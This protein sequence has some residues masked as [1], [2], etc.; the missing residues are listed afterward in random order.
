M[1]KLNSN[2]YEIDEINNFRE[3][4]DG[5]VRKYPN[6]IAYKFKKDLGKP[7]Q[8]IVEK[9]YKQIKEEIEALST[10]LL[11]LDLENEK[12]I[13]IS[14]NRYEWCIS[15]FAITTGNMVVVPLDKLLPEKEI[16][17][18]ILKSKAT[19]AIFENRKKVA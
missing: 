1:E 14:N 17:N 16:E 5:S 3:L 18:L 6:N 2:L 11:E 7:T 10:S 8:T 13:L 12:I 4:I 15:Y 9:T 19:V